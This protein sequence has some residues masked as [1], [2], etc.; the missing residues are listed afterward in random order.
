M[1]VA[2]MPATV[3]GPHLLSPI[4]SAE[5]LSLHLTRVIAFAARSDGSRAP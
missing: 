3:R 2:G 5:K 4:K 1:L